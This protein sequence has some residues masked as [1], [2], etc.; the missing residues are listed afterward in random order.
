MVVRNAALRWP[1]ELPQSIHG[2]RFGAIDRRAKYLLMPLERGGLIVHLGMSGHMA[3]TPAAKP[4]GQHDHVDF[5]LDDG[6]AVRFTDPRRFGSIHWQP[7]AIAGHWLLAGLGPEP[8]S[9]EFDGSHLASRARNRRMAIKALVMD[10]KVVVGVGNIYA[11]E[12]L[13]AAGVRPRIAA[14]RISKR[15]LETLAQA[16]KATL[17]SAI[18]S[19][20]TTLRDFAAAD[21]RPG[22][23]VHQ[24]KVYGRGGEPCV[25]CAEP[26]KELRLAGRAT[27]YCPACQ[28]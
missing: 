8:L 28:T 10:A 9:A 11:A 17:T 22:Y 24:L 23:F 13:F 3:V 27:V 15:R 21:G 6:N 20:G 4:P 1:V 14:G 26:L 7:G 25:R 2:Q 16:I 18:E 19:G 12:A 5:V